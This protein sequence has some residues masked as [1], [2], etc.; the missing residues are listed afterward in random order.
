MNFFQSL[1]KA[2]EERGSIKKGAFYG[3]ED[4]VD[5]EF[6][7][8]HVN[9][10]TDKV[11]KKSCVLDPSLY[12][13]WEDTNLGVLMEYQD[14]K[15]KVQKN[16][17]YFFM[18]SEC[19]THGWKIDRVGSTVEYNN[20]AQKIETLSISSFINGLKEMQMREE[21]CSQEKISKYSR[22]ITSVLEQ[23]YNTKVVESFKKGVIPTQVKN[24]DHVLFMGM[25]INM[26][27]RKRTDDGSFQFLIGEKREDRTGEEAMKAFA[28]NSA[29][30]LDVSSLKDKSEI[31]QE[32]CGS[33]VGDILS[34]NDDDLNLRIVSEEI[35]VNKNTL[36]RLKKEDSCKF[37]K[38]I[39][40]YKIK[41]LKDMQ[42]AQLS[43]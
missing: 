36:Y 20:K 10:S 43:F 14:S 5:I 33:A 13:G 37:Q 17:V 11:M 4:M 24:E 39:D 21:G 29:G 41:I 19:Y 15:S 38:Y 26:V 30:V 8:L 7:T 35:G 2:R 22:N 6:T 12:S 25:G 42:A 31:E 27:M 16:G 23:I 40:L 32:F 3:T 9:T 28:L 34:L 1:K 18:P